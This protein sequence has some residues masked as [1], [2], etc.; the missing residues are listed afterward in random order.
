MTDRPTNHNAK[1]KP[2][3]PSLEHSLSR[4]DCGVKTPS[5]VCGCAPRA[6]VVWGKP[7]D[8]E[9]RRRSRRR[10]GGADGAS[11]EWS[12]G[13]DGDA[14][15]GTGEDGGTGDGG[16]ARAVVVH[17]GVVQLYHIIPSDH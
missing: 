12:D 13:V 16:E 8:D 2:S 11:P 6:S 4:P 10:E 15:F 7:D 17:W 14:D 3:V 1:K 5:V 9:R